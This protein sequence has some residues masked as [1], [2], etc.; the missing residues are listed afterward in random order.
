[1]VTRIRKGARTH[2]YIEEH[3][4]ARGLSDEKLGNRLDVSR[5]TIHRWKREQWRLDP[6]K[7]AA[8]AEALDLEGPQD[9]YRPPTRPSID[10]IMMDAPQSLYDAMVEHAK[11]LRKAG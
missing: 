8:L 3:Q 4:E 2:L 9:L 10:A 5:Q 6:L 7:M 11:S 1:M